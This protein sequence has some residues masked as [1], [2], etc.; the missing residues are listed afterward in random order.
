ML[1]AFFRIIAIIGMS[2]LLAGCGSSAGTTPGFG[3]MLAN[4]SESFP[5]LWRLVTG[6]AY[7]LGFVM[8]LGGIYQLRAYAEPHSMMRGSS[9]MKGPMVTIFVGSMLIF[10]PTAFHSVLVTMFGAGAHVTPLSY[11]VNDLGIESE[12]AYKG[13]LEF[14]QFVGL[15]SFIR[16]WYLLHKATQQSAQIS[17]A[18]GLTHII[19]GLL[20]INIV[21]TRDVFLY[22]FGFR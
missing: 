22:T 10:S 14:V 19:G 15:M 21:A 1:R 8:V 18:K 17:H 9:N 4:L 3:Q 13:L 6:G 5:N 2:M 7:V 20:A 11:A 12:L 16:G